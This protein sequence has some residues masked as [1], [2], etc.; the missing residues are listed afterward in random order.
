MIT[1]EEKTSDS[2]EQIAETLDPAAKQTETSAEQ[3]SVPQQVSDSSSATVQQ[4]S[5]SMQSGF[6]FTHVKSCDIPLVMDV[7]HLYNWI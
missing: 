7:I 3:Q 2:K 5:T 4:V 6:A 1:T